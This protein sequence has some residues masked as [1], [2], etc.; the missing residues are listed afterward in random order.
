M[1]SLL[2]SASGS[3]KSLRS[4]SVRSTNT[5]QFWLLRC[6]AAL[7]I[8]TFPWPKQPCDRP[9]QRGLSHQQRQPG[10]SQMLRLPRHRERSKSA[11]PA[12]KKRRACIASLPKYCACHAKHENDLPFCDFGTDKKSISCET[13]SAFHTLKDRMV[14]QCVCPAQ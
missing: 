1:A 4:V 14:S 5:W 8:V 9:R 10:L 12:T 2:P 11:A 7:R 13:S 6:T 3:A